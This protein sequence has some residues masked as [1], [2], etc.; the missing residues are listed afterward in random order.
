MSD[1]MPYMQNV[2]GYFNMSTLDVA[3]NRWVN[4]VTGGNDITINGGA[5]ENEALKLVEGEWGELIIDDPDVIYIVC[6]K[7]VSDDLSCIIG[8]GQIGGTRTD[9]S[10]FNYVTPSCR[11]SAGGAPYIDANVDITNYIV[12]ALA[13]MYDVDTE[14]KDAVM[15]FVNGTLYGYMTGTNKT[16]YAGIVTVNRHCIGEDVYNTPGVNPLYIK[17]IVTGGSHTV[18]QIISNSKYFMGEIIEDTK[19][20]MAGADA[21]A[22]AWCMA[23][24]LQQAKSLQ[25]Q[26]LSYR[27]GIIDGDDEGTTNEVIDDEGST[28]IEIPVDPEE[29]DPDKVE[30]VA[31]RGVTMFYTA[32]D[33]ETGE[34]YYIRIYI[35]DEE[36]TGSSELGTYVYRYAD[37]LVYDLYDSNGNVIKTAGIETY[38]NYVVPSTSWFITPE[39]VGYGYEGYDTTMYVNKVSVSGRYIIVDYTLINNSYKTTSRNQSVTTITNLPEGTAIIRTTS[40]KPF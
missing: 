2:T 24:T 15:L 7:P 6:K 35:N 25:N 32:E 4:A 40:E 14:G 18:E 12:V 9:L 5:V 29:T 33:S 27:K 20:Q 31:E 23:T 10:L 19:S 37:T 21:A 22:I 36:G 13:R 34:K 11:L 26:L 16:N 8:R 17:A 39:Y 38:W 30:K 28:P 1:K 3:N